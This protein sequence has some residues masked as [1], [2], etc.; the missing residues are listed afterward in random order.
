MFVSV[1]QCTALQDSKPDV[2][3]KASAFM[4]TKL[5]QDHR[6]DSINHMNA[7]QWDH[8]L[9]LSGIAGLVPRRSAVPNRAPLVS[10]LAKA[11][12]AQGVCAGSASVPGA[13][14]PLPLPLLPWGEFNFDAPSVNV[15]SIRVCSVDTC[16][17]NVCS[18]QCVLQYGQQGCWRW[19][20]AGS[21]SCPCI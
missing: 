7:G 1:A 17:T 3:S 4:V 14:A 18:I 5:S 20:Q 2:A 19:Y 11:Q 21:C 8:E 16:S 13:G 9:E 15:C 6:K 12:P 10:W